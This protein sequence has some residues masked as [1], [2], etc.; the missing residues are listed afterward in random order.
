[1]TV[2]RGRRRARSTPGPGSAPALSGPDDERAAGVEPRDRSA[3]GADGVDRERRAAGSGTR[4][5]TRVGAGA[6]TPPAR[7]T[8]RCWC[9]PCR[10]TTASAKPHAAATAAAAR[11]PPAGPDSSSRAGCAAASASGTS[12]PADVITSTSSASAREP[13]RGTARTP[14]R[15]AASATVVT[16]RSYSRNS[17]DTSCE[18]TTSRPRAREHRRDRAFV[19]RIEIG[20]Q[21]AH[22]DRVDRR[23]CR[24]RRRRT[25]R[26][27]DPCASS[28]PATS[29]R[30]ARGTSGAR[31]IDVRVVERR[32]RLARDLDHVGEAAGRDQRDAAEPRARAARWSRP[33]CRARA[34][35][36]VE[37]DRAIA[38]PTAR[39]GSAGVDGTFTTV[40]SSATRSVNV[41][42]V[43]TPTR[44]R[45]TLRDAAAVG[46]SAPFSSGRWARVP[47]GGS[48]GRGRCGP[49]AR[50]SR[51]GGAAGACARR[52]RC[53]WGSRP[54]TPGARACHARPPR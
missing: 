26:A 43:S 33:S 49:R 53:G 6:G 54:A 12:P 10:T 4:R 35:R 13:A 7:G 29:N 20:V 3:T 22:R 17:G 48:H 19:R 34:R 9:R 44:M 51:S 28:R 42:P 45:P 21:Q 24:A 32:P 39:A 36:A 16:M 18:H 30:S 5:P 38:S 37:R 23:R 2:G 8:R 1:M 11:T 14:A 52:A 41:P 31:S 46:V 15:S 50:A 27:R 40:P 25:A 47:G